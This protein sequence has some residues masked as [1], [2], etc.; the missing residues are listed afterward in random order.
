[1]PTFV[2]I[3]QNVAAVRAFDGRDRGD[4]RILSRGRTFF[5]AQDDVWREEKKA[6]GKAS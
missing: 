4:E 1:M 2:I 3:Y 6:W 5:A